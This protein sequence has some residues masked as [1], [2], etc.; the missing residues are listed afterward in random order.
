[1]SLG[2]LCVIF[3][4]IGVVT[5]GVPK[6]PFL[7]LA[8]FFFSRSSKKMHDMLMNNKVFGKY[9]YNYFNGVP[10]PLK[11]KIFTIVFLWISLG[12]SLYL[13]DFNQLLLILFPI[14][15]ISVSIHVLTLGKWRKKSKNKN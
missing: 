15:G 10:F 11:D 1:M 3:A 2:V 14:I 5:P 13:A 9:L 7:L 4:C 12:I 8:S 6:T